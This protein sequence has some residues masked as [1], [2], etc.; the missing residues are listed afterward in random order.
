MFT[1]KPGLHFHEVVHSLRENRAYLCGHFAVIYPAQ[2]GKVSG[3]C[4]VEAVIE[5][6]VVAIREGDHELSSFLS[7][8]E[9]DED[10]HR[11]GR[12]DSFHMSDRT[13]E[14]FKRF[15]KNKPLQTSAVSHNEHC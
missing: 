2:G 12:K 10:T 3:L 4:T 7:N 1:F 15:K 8:L 14:T 5:A 11:G 9:K 13:V 6:C